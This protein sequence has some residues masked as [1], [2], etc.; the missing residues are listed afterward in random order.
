MRT[1]V[2]DFRQWRG[3][4][5]L[6]SALVMLGFVICHLTAH[7]LLLVSFEDAEATRNVLMY[8]W[9]TWIGTGILIAAFL[10]HYSN[11]LWSIYIRRSLRL[12]RWEWAQLSLG[13]C[14][15]AAADVPCR[16]DAHRRKRARRHHLLQH[17]LYRSV[18]DVSMARRRADDRGGDGV[19]SCLHRHPLLASHQALVSEMAAAVFQLRP[20]AADAWR[21]PVMSPAATRSCAR[22][23][24]IPIL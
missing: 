24:P 19:D 3:R 2:W 21:S 6:A 10:V 13:L 8:P 18:A 16:G 14:I 23:R 20:V 22:P 5:R 7:C 17:G 15:P 9:R 12:N 4:L 11:A 1:M